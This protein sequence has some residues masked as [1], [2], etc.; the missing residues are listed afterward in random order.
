[1]ADPGKA[2]TQDEL[3][4]ALQLMVRET[5]RS[6]ED[7]A[8]RARLSGNTVRGVL[9]GKN[10]PQQRTLEQ[11]VE[12]CGQ[13]PT[14]WVE[15]WGALN[16]AR[17]RTERGGDKQLQEQVDALAAEVRSLRQDVEQ[18][19][20]GDRRRQR[21]MA[22]AYF[23]F[24]ADMP[25]AQFRQ[26]QPNGDGS[27]PLG[28]PT[29]DKTYPEPVYGDQAVTV[30]LGKVAEL[31]TAEGL[32]RLAVYLATSPLP[33]AFTTT[34]SASDGYAKDDVDAYLVELRSCVRDYLRGCAEAV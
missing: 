27:A 23:S 28:P 33:P 12:A 32:P 20:T 16:D 19:E 29:R 3:L 18:G 1:M 4:Q 2:D 13:D 5:R 34:L 8:K 22:D 10:W 14:V 26:L 25:T 24:L 6:H 31:A 9:S 11:L 21:R 30:L 7:I 17:P 15:V